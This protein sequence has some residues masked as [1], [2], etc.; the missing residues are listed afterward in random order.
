[1]IRIVFALLLFSF[2]SMVAQAQS[3]RSEIINSIAFVDVGRIIKEAR[4]SKNLAEKAKKANKKLKA[5]LDRTVQQLRGEMNTIRS[6]VGSISKQALEEKQLKLQ[7]KE[8]QERQKLQQQQAKIRQAQADAIKQVDS[9]VKTIIDGIAQR[10]QYL[11]V[12]PSQ[13]AMYYNPSLDI[14]D[15]VIKK[16]DARL[17]KVDFDY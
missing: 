1:M 3:A 8:L 10:R 4:A 5:D 11:M 15:E 16:L 17:T 7:Q 9:K 13:T 6:Q 12:I 14:T 2:S